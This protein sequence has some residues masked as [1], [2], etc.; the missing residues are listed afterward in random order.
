MKGW[1]SVRGMWGP[2]SP[3]PVNL[4]GRLLVTIVGD[5]SF[6]LS[7]LTSHHLIP[8]LCELLRELR[9]L[10]PA[11]PACSLEGSLRGPAASLKGSEGWGRDEFCPLIMPYNVHHH[12][13]V[14]NTLGTCCVFA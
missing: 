5:R 13:I 12:S 6:P 11:E 8:L 10:L 14:V 9:G 1:R 2:L 7:L 3:V 4:F